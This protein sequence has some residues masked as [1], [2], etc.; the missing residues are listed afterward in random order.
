MTN[1]WT[2]GVN[3]YH[4]NPKDGFTPV[5]KERADA[6]VKSIK[7]RTPDNVVEIEA[8]NLKKPKN[9]NLDDST[10]DNIE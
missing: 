3:Q 5:D 6:I 7:D 4:G 8:L 10:I 1:L 2:D 9:L